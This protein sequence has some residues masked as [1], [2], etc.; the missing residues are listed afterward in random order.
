M[1]PGQRE[2]TA[3]LGKDGE[4]VVALMIEAGDV[5]R[6]EQDI[7]VHR[8]AIEKAKQEI[9]KLLAAK[10]QAGLGEIREHLGITRKFVLPLLLYLD[11]IGFTEREGDVRKLRS[12]T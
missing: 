6:L 3:G 11:S 10:H 9:T 1:P 8:S 2:I 5:V 4:K 7:V 12:A